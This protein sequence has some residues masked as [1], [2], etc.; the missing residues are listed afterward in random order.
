MNLKFINSFVLFNLNVEWSRIYFK[1]M[2]ILNSEK[3][4]VQ[5]QTILFKEPPL[6]SECIS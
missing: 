1:L 2:R 4:S 5:R 6:L 3:K